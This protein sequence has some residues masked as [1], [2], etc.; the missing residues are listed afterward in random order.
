MI[1][2]LSTSQ[3]TVKPAYAATITGS[4]GQVIARFRVKAIKALRPDVS[5]K[6]EKGKGY[7][8]AIIS[9]P[10]LGLAATSVESRPLFVTYTNESK[11][12][13][14]LIESDGRQVYAGYVRGT[15]SIYQRLPIE[16]YNDGRPA[17]IIVTHSCQRQSPHARFAGLWCEAFD[18]SNESNRRNRK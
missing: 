12:I 6:W 1:R 13:C 14:T 16:V 2:N 7:P 10:V 9:I 18:L 4:N 5:A 8:D 17:N 11:G 15:G 3:N